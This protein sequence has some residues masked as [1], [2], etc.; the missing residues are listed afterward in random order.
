MNPT[1]EQL[2]SIYIQAGLDPRG[3]DV[4]DF[5]ARMTALKAPTL[6][7]AKQVA[8]EIASQKQGAGQQRPVR[9]AGKPSSAS[10]TETSGAEDIDQYWEGFVQSEYRKQAHYQGRELKDTELTGTETIE[11]GLEEILR[12]IQ[13]GKR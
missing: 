3:D 7:D 12:D 2:T 6:E 10:R 9:P 5:V 4:D 13:S 1:A 8:A 11:K